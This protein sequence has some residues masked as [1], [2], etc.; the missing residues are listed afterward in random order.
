M[1]ESLT[2]KSL[3]CEVSV[4]K[5]FLNEVSGA[6]S[7]IDK[8]C[9]KKRKKRKSYWMQTLK[10]MEPYVL[11]IGLYFTMS[12]WCRSG[13]FIVSFCANFVPSSGA[14]AVTSEQVNANLVCFS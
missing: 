3:V 2:R 9:K 14:S 7:I 5:G 12:F 4:T 13:A 8:K 6:S 10:S 1:L 11:N